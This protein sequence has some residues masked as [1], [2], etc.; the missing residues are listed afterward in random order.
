VHKCHKSIGGSCPKKK[1][2][3]V[4]KYFTWWIGAFCSL[5]LCFWI[6]GYFGH[7]QKIQILG[8]NRRVFEENIFWTKI[9]NV[10][11]ILVQNCKFLWRDRIC[12]DFIGFDTYRIKNSE[13][14]KVWT[15]FV[16]KIIF[17]VQTWVSQWKDHLCKVL[18]ALCHLR[19]LVCIHDWR[20][21]LLLIFQHLD[22]FCQKIS[23]RVFL[24]VC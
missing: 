3:C 14:S 11:K 20:E 21:G 13:D 23:Q 15:G 22:Q 8:R 24:D 6:K 16:K 4:W 7:F 2:N 18:L 9:V 12:T 1:P 10:F 17:G 5:I 19:V